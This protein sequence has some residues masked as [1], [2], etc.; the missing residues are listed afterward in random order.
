MEN[1][2]TYKA[3]GLVALISVIREQANGYIESE[4]K[5]CGAHGLLPAHGVIL[6]YL[7]RSGGSAV[8]TDIVRVS[9]KAKSTITVMVNTLEKYGYITKNDNPDDGRSCIIS[10]TKRAIE[11][12]PQFKRISDEMN[13]KFLRGLSDDEQQ[14]M[15]KLLYTV[16]DNFFTNNG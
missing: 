15:M 2:T 4:L 7:Y 1:K 13:A 3:E 8:I 5:K 6:G 16:R 11:L 14:T 10:L 12:E 9:K